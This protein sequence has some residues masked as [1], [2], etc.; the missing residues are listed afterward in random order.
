MITYNIV[1][2]FGSMSRKTTEFIIVMVNFIS[3]SKKKLNSQSNVSEKSTFKNVLKWHKIVNL[4]Q[5]YQ[6]FAKNYF[7]KIVNTIA[8]DQ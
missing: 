3:F 4:K 1:M 5:K 6:N 7:T 8:K 2:I